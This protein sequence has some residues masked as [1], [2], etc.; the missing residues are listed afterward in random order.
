MKTRI[1]RDYMNAL[2]GRSLRRTMLAPRP[3]T[4]ALL[5]PCALFP[6]SACLRVNS[7]AITNDGLISLES[8]VT[9]PDEQRNLELLDLE[10][11]VASLLEDHRQHH[12]TADAGWT[13][14]ER[15]YRLTVTGSGHLR[16]VVGTT[17][18]YKLER[19]SESQSTFIIYAFTENDVRVWLRSPKGS[20]MMLTRREG[21]CS[22]KAFQRRSLS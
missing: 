8:V 6:L 12:W 5:L 14:Q 11:A 4:S 22:R 7:I 9:E 18:S 21:P 2:N 15:P 17:S 20:A 3:T 19:I 16:D 1:E 13:S 10:K